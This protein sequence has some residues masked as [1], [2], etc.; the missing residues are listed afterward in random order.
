MEADDTTTTTTGALA[1]LIQLERRMDAQL[2]DAEA[3]A[4]RRVEVARRAALA[5]LEG[6]DPSGQ[7][8]LAALREAVARE[9]DLAVR[10]AEE[11]ARVD[12]ECYE[13]LDDRAVRE[14]ARCVVAWLA[15]GQAP[16]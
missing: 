10:E 13:R 16:T 2:A 6:S 14:L 11:R 15:G 5:G 4:A 7:E 1:E 8:A 9:C 12:A 3:E